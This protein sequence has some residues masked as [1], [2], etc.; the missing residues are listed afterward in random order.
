MRANCLKGTPAIEKPVIPGSATD[1]LLPGFGHCL[2]FC[3][4][5]SENSR[6]KSQMSWLSARLATIPDLKLPPQKSVLPTITAG[7]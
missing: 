3:T 2:A 4:Q 5:G 6:E 7:D 1:S